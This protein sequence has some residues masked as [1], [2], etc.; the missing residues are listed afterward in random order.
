M[1]SAMQLVLGC[2]QLRNCGRTYPKVQAVEWTSILS[3]QQSP[4]KVAI[5]Q[6]MD[7]IPSLEILA[8]KKAVVLNRLQ[9][10]AVAMF[11]PFSYGQPNAH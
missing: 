11:S 9:F 1:T 8:S 3:G 2:A 5:L 7:E 4:V 10:G 6:V